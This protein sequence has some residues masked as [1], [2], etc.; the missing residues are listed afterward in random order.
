MKS[1][2]SA[3]PS[4]LMAAKWVAADANGLVYVS[5]AKANGILVLAADGTERFGLRARRVIRC[6]SMRRPASPYRAPGCW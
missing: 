6:R 5:L 2:T 1:A 4:V 3:K